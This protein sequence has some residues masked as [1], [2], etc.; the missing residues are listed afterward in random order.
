MEV[1]KIV[2]LS[3]GSIAVLFIISKI[4]GNK[5]MSQLNLFDYIIGI[6]IGSIAAEMATALESNF[7]QPLT[8]II[9]YGLVTALISLIT[10][11]SFKARRIIEGRTLILLDNGKLYR[12]NFK[13]GKVDINEFLMQCRAKGYFNISE[14]QTAV[15]EAN[16]K[17]SFLPKVEKRPATPEDLNLNIKQD[18]LVINVVLDGVLLEENLKILGKDKSWL[19]KQARKQGIKDISKIFLATCDKEENLSI[20][21]KVNNDNVDDMF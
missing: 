4:M 8:A 3:I 6:T 20:Y 16:G 10:N 14:I 11:H 21:M 15:L 18:K 17:I 19:E 13:K 2:W 9:V 7:V 12:N 5:E 1:L